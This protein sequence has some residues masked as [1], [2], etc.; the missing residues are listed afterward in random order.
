[1]MDYLLLSAALSLGQTGSDPPVPLPEPP[2]FAAAIQPAAPAEATKQAEALPK[3]VEVVAPLL[4]EPK[5]ETPAEE[6]PAAAAAAGD[7]WLLMRSLQGTWPGAL[8]DDHRMSIWGWTAGSYTASSASKINSPVVWNDKA[9]QFL[10]QQHWMRFERTVV[11]SGTTEPTFG[12]RSDWLIG[13]DYRFTLP[14]GIFNNQFTERDNGLPNDYGVDPIAFYAQAYFP[15]V[16]NGL[17]VKVGRYFTPFGVE[18]LEAI[19]TPTV[20]RSYAFNWAPPFTHTGF[21]A[22]LTVNPKW[23]V[24]GGFALGNDVFIDPADE[25]RFVGFIKYTAPNARD[26][27]TFGTSIGRGKFN[28][29]ENF[30]HINVFDVVWTHVINSRL[31]YNLEVIHGYQTNVPQ[32]GELAPQLDDGGNL[33]LDDTGSVVLVPKVGTAHWGSIVN[34]LFYTFT[35]RLTGMARFELFDDFDGHRT[36]FE[37]LYTAATVGLN[38]KPYKSLWIRPELRYDYNGES[39]PFEGKNWLVTAATDVIFR[40]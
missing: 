12:F 5:A 6:A 32:P 29:V 27:L 38:F 37:G 4:P 1:M 25:G 31:T 28:E 14:R 3:P 11:T 16:G 30:N 20:S 40:W 19:S 18:S 7:R 35:P 36:G 15:T 39:Q 34:Y 8:L 23:T 21:L 17:D 10:L 22:T 2:P 24:A 13:S 33:V 26:T 9:D